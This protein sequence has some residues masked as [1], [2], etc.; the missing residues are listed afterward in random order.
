MSKKYG[1][2]LAF[3]HFMVT[4][5]RSIWL[6]WYTVYNT[7]KAV[8]T[9][10]AVTSA[11]RLPAITNCVCNKKITEEEIGACAKSAYTRY[12]ASGP[13][14]PFDECSAECP[15]SEV[16][17]QVPEPRIMFFFMCVLLFGM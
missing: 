11:Y 12:L 10:A 7:F 17:I 4:E 1:K 3:A 6:L 13:Q 2:V 8:V 15:G 9:S 5:M 14:D 16:G